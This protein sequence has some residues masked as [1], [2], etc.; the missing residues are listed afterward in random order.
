MIADSAANGSDLGYV[1]RFRRYNHAP[2]CSRLDIVIHDRPTG[3]HFDPERVV[4]SVASA[5]PSH[6]GIEHLTIRHRWQGRSSYRPCACPLRMIDRYNKV[7]VAFTFGGTLIIRADDDKTSLTLISPVPILH[8]TSAC[9]PPAASLLAI[10]MQVLLARRRAAW[11]Y[12][13]P[14]EF[15]RRLA[16]AAPGE[17]YR[18][19]IEAIRGGFMT[20]P[21]S[22]GYGIVNFRHFLRSE[23]A[24]LAAHQDSL[25]QSLADLL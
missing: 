13:D 3:R 6:M 8:V 16:R 14:A 21:Q 17:L 15:E 5:Q 10:E 24:Y 22:D 19:C 23:L 20:C 1:F 2:G 9:N 12:K 4:V 7:E 11:L 25:P 18:C